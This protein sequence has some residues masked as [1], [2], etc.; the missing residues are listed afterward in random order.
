[1]RKT[2]TSLTALCLLCLLTAACSN[3]DGFTPTP[4]DETRIITF[5]MDYAER[6][7]SRATSDTY[8]AYDASKHPSS[9]GVYGLNDIFSNQ[10]VT[11]ANDEWTYTPLKYWNAYT[12]LSSFDFFAYMPQSTAATLTPTT[13]GATDYTLSYPVSISGGFI[14]DSRNVPLICALPNHQTTTGNTVS[15]KMDQVLGGYTVEFKLDDQMDKIRDFVIKAVKVYGTVATSGKV[16]RTYSWNGSAWTAGDVTWSNITTTSITEA[17]AISVYAAADQ[18]LTLNGDKTDYQA[19]QGT[20][21]GIPDTFHPFS[22][23]V[24]YDVTVDEDGDTDGSHAV[25]RQGVVNTLAISSDN[26]SG[27]TQAI[28]KIGKLQILIKPNYL[29]VL[30]DDDQKGFV[31]VN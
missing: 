2:I 10:E 26:F 31:I 14:T 12:S 27:I 18:T 22:L 21:F 5:G 7:T 1:M 30:A 23:Q 9:M 24:T 17:N 3:S 20:F 11:Y 13:A 4:S 16:S 28:D 6:M 25:T 15:F 29:Y 19:W 8:E